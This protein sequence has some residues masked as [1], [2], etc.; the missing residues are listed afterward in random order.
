MRNQSKNCEKSF[1]SHI[2]T[3]AAL[4]ALVA[5]GC[6]GDDSAPSSG[7]A[8]TQLC[9]LLSSGDIMEVLRKGT[10][11]PTP[12]QEGVGHCTWPSLDGSATVVELVLESG[13]ERPPEGVPPVVG[14][15]D[16]A[17]YLQD[18]HMIRVFF[19]EKVLNVSAPGADE[20]QLTDLASRSMASLRF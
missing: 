13:G 19:D 17:I 5:L 8:R 11:D 1:L 9:G 20:A 3:L 4:S 16:W 12:G 6:G 14:L 18:E 7:K 2:V 10:S 15:S